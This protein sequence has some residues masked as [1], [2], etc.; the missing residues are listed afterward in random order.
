MSDQIKHRACSANV[1]V[2]I[3]EDDGTDGIWYIDGL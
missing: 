2:N 1:M 3:M